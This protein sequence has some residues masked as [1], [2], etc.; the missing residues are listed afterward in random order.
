MPSE[1]KI[2]K[3]TR[4]V[5]S[6]VSEWF[7]HMLEP[8]TLEAFLQD[9]QVYLESGRDKTTLCDMATYVIEAMDNLWAS[10]QSDQPGYD[11]HKGCSWCCYQNV[12]V[13]W[14]ELLQLMEF[15]RETLNADQLKKLYA[16]SQLRSKEVIGKTT[17]QRF[18]E[19]AA[20]IFLENKICTIHTVRP[21]QCRGG[22][23]EDQ[24]YCKNLL[25]NREQTQQ[26]VKDGDQIGKFLIAPKFIYNSAQVAMLYAMKESGFKGFVFELT[27]AM[28]ILL[29]KLLDGQFESIKEDDLKPA[30]LAKKNDEIKTSDIPTS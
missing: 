15:L 30:L 28:T 23:S 10:I 6:E 27:L 22:F 29:Q 2:N 4:F 12:S 7:D 1:N 13:T 19:R 21:L 9:C 16:K 20:C 25:E 3:F 11:C 8:A 17:N 14:P 5:N 24:N 18:D 26:A